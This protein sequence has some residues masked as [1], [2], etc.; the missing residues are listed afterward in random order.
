MNAPLTAAQLTGRERGHLVPCAGRHYLHPEAARAL[1]AL[2]EKAREAGF[3]LALASSFR[4]YERQL[5]IFNGKACGERPVHDDCGAT[6]AM[7]ALTPAGQ[8]AAILRFSALPGTSRHHWGTDI[9]VYDAAAVAADYRVQLTPA[10]VAAGGVFDDFHCWLDERIARGES[11]GFF[12]PYAVDRGGVAP[13]RW[14]LSYAP[15][16][17]RCATPDEGDLLALW[18]ETGLA[19]L[20]EVEAQLQQLLERYVTVPEG[21]CPQPAG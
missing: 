12:R 4:S 14:H 10:E 3:E 5:A 18:R 8:L 17:L 13:E 21:W 7:E 9:D 20:D 15:V 2:Q 19:L 16:S 1:V 11:E 6:V